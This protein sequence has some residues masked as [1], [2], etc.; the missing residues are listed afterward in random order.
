MAK[1]AFKVRVER[2]DGKII[3]WL[4]DTSFKKVKEIVQEY[5]DSCPYE[6][7]WDIWGRGK[8]FHGSTIGRDS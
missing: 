5:A 3:Y 8:D 7:E 4:F 2:T 1:E 6:C